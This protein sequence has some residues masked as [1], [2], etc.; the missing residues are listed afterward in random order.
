[1]IDALVIMLTGLIIGWLVSYLKTKKRIIL[2]SD[3]I[4]LLSVLFLLF[5]MGIFVGSNQLIMSQL[6]YLGLQAISIALAAIFGS[7]ICCALLYVLLFKNKGEKHV[8]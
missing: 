7:V 8:N 5:L 1:M 6:S 2:L 4:T 3:K